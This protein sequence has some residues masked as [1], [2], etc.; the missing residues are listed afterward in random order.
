MSDH[1]TTEA[2]P[3][4]PEPEAHGSAAAPRE[5]LLL[6]I[7]LPVGGLVVIGLVLFL[8]SRILLHITHD[9]A[10]VVA[11]ITAGAIIT[12]C[13]AVASRQRL[14]NAALL[15]MIGTIIGIALVAGGVAMV[16]IGPEKEE[17]QPQAVTLTA[18]VGAASKGFQPT[19]LKLEAN[20]ATTLTFDNQ[21][22]NVSHNVV[23]FKGKDAN[24]E[25]EF[26]GALTSGPSNTPYAVPGLPAGSYFFH[27]EV[28]PTTMTGTISVEVTAAPSGSGPPPPSGPVITATG[29]QFNEAQLNFTADQPT[30]LTFTNNDAGTQHNVDIYK[31]SAFTTDVF[32]GDLVTGPDTVQ[33]QVP[34]LPAGT[35]YFKCDVHP[36]MTGTLVA[37]P[38]AGGGGA[39]GGGS[40]SPGSEAPS[41]S[42]SP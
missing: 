25:T 16:A 9:A 13:T 42:G 24:G 11:C 38:A 35:Y 40:G 32:K 21:D 28:H 10:T 7:L 33:Y 19:S 29:L 31:D 30:V 14:S 1:D 5:G 12:V 20:R 36:T 4:P 3:A 18:P 26:T 34:A 2:P 27:C 6:P 41:A 37:A 17:E 8:F 23:I 39:G 15:P 22:P